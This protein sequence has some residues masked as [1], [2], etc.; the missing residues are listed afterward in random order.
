MFNHILSLLILAGVVFGVSY[1][2][3]GVKCKS[4][5]TAI[6]VA[7]VMS[8]LNWLIYTVFPIL[9]IPLIVL[10]G[11]VGFFLIAV[12]VLWLTNKLVENFEIQGTGTLLIAALLIAVA[13]LLLRWLL[14]S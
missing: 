8:L 6:V 11:G 14:V 10:T 1:L 3:P 5:G 4:F 9:A 13:N 12:F 2:L 7:I